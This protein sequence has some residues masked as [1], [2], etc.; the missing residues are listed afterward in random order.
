ME[1]KSIKNFEE[2]QSTTNF[3]RK[4]FFFSKCL[5]AKSKF[6]S[7][8][9]AQFIQINDL[10]QF[11]MIKQ[12]PS[13]QWDEFIKDQFLHPECWVNIKQISLNR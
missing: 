6:P 13:E 8:D 10:Y 4:K 5:I 7:R 11:I 12:I 2:N 1:E 3:D 9:P